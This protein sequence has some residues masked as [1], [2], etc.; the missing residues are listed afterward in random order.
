MALHCG[1][2]LRC[3]MPFCSDIPLCHDMPSCIYAEVTYTG[4]R[5]CNLCAPGVCTKTRMLAHC[6]MPLYKSQVRRECASTCAATLLQ[7]QSMRAFRTTQADFSIASSERTLTALL[8]A[9]QMVRSCCTIACYSVW[10]PC[11]SSWRL[12][13]HGSTSRDLGW[14]LAWRRTSTLL[15]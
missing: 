5:F 11:A 4:R 1:M 10:W 8:K 3:D 12:A 6:M 14:L 2:S 7:T 15:P 13:T 9:F